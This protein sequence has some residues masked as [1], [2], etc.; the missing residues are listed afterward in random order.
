MKKSWIV[1]V[2]ASLLIPSVVCADL[3]D[4]ESVNWDSD[5]GLTASKPVCT[6]AS[7]V[8]AVC[9]GTE[10]VWQPAAAPLTTLSGMA[11]IPGTASPYVWVTQDGSEG[12]PTLLL[13]GGNNYYIGSNTDNSALVSKSPA[14]VLSDI[15]AAPASNIALTALANQAPN[16]V[17]MNATPG[18]AAPTA[19]AIAEQQFPCRPTGEN[20]KA[21]TAAEGLAL[22][23][24]APAAGSTSIVSYGPT[25][26]QNAACSGN[27]V[28]I[29]PTAGL[30][31][32][33][34]T[35]TQTGDANCAATMSETGAVEGSI[36]IIK[37]GSTGAANTVTFTTSAGVQVLIQGSPFAL[38]LKETLILQYKGSEWLEIGRA[39][40]T[41]NIS[42]ITVGNGTTSSGFIYFAEDTDNGS[43]KVKLEAPQALP[44]DVTV[45]LPDWT[46]TLTG[47]VGANTA[48]LGTSEIASGACA[49]A[50]TVS[51]T[52]VATT[53][54]IDWGFNGDP[55]S[56]T[57]YSPSA[58]GM[59]TIIA[60]PT[61]GNV[62]FKVCNN[63]AGAVTP[64][65]VTLNFK[66][67]K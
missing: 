25:E 50:V 61:S 23:G 9:G 57:G 22:F 59:L 39:S 19:V 21:C 55:T 47:T 52:G 2:L 44:G 31:V 17:L 3:Y 5:T 33:N 6:N 53:D 29:T 65:A 18:A 32:S 34:I 16:T 27:A 8:L 49:S 51:V 30:G 35:V 14:T 63:T 1:L 43:S 10:G 67:R 15:G 42:S 54:V 46:T 45:T 62:N 13:S 28:T 66:V 56:T 58:N 26:V 64:G 24:A 41:I 36:A 37:N 12:T 20:I 4:S 48:A 11:L 7:G 40:A 60:Y 38:A